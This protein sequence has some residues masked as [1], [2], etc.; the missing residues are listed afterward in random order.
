MN[1]KD[2]IAVRK[3]ARDP[4]YAILHERERV[5]FVFYAHLAQ[6]NPKSREIQVLMQ[7][8]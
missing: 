3:C 6:H 4:P 5:I 2:V 7:N 1:K 8:G